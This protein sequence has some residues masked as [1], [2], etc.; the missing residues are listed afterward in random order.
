VAVSRIDRTTI[1]DVAVIAL[2]DTYTRIPPEGFVLP[3]LKPDFERYAHLLEPD[4]AAILS[5]TAFLLESAGRRILVDTGL[6]DQTLSRSATEE[7]HLLPEVMTDA[8]YPPESVDIVVHTH[9]HFDHVGWN[10][11]VRGGVRVPTFPNAHHLISTL[12]WDF[13]VLQGPRASGPDYERYLKPLDEKGM[14]GLID[15]D[16][17]RV[18]DDV[19]VIHARGHTPGHQ[20]VRIQSRGEVGY[21]IGDACHMPAQAC[22]PQWSSRADIDPAAAAATR[23]ALFRRIEDEDALVLSGHFP[24]PGMG[25]LVTIDGRRDYRPIA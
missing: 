17:H 5:I 12:D 8:G 24:F 3:E 13:W 19:S 20:A 10:T 6:N 25:R 1:G 7:P 2:R 22:E 21:I 11:R 16:D 14:I 9:L 15:E 18:T 4:G 23:A